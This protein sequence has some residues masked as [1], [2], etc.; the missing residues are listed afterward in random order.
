MK[1]I[2]VVAEK[3]N[4]MAIKFSHLDFYGRAVS[5]KNIGLSPKQ[6]TELT[7]QVAELRKRHNKINITDNLVDK[8]KLLANP[9]KYRNPSL[10][11]LP[12]GTVLPWYG[13]P[14][15]FALWKYPEE[16]LETL[17]ESLLQKRILGFY[18]LL[19]KS[20][21]SIRHSCKQRLDYDNII[22]RFL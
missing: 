5:C 1:K 19:D 11:I 6:L 22:M 3:L 2:A 10:H 4:V 18:K 9:E 15:R 20:Q 21:K 17:S 12:N 13:L 14:E 8:D 16:S 7:N